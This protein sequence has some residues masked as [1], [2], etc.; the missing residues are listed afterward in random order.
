MQADLRTRNPYPEFNG[1]QWSGWR[2]RDEN[3]T[4]SKKLYSCQENALSD[5]L[6][7][8]KRL[9]RGPSVWERIWAGL[10]DWGRKFTADE[11]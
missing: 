5:M 1:R 2:W 11:S 9:R 3:G 7:H 10:L 8:I 4:P 6:R